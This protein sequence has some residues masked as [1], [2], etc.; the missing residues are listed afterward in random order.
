MDPPRLGAVA[1]LREVRVSRYTIESLRFGAS[2]QRI[3][4]HHVARFEFTAEECWALAAMIPAG[5]GARQEF[6]DA[7]IE[8]EDVE[9]GPA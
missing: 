2:G 9:G 3:R 1:V 4:N 5:D 7:A 8:L 6:C